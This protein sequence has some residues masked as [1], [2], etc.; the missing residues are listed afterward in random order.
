MIVRAGSGSSLAAAGAGC[1]GVCNSSTWLAAA[2]VAGHKARVA[3]MTQ[4]AMRKWENRQTAAAVARWVPLP[5]SLLPTRPLHTLS[6][7]SGLSKGPKQ[8]EAD[9]Q[10]SA[11]VV[12]WVVPLSR[13]R[14]LRIFTEVFISIV[15]K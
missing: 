12:V 13:Q 9:G 3:G 1:A 7:F 6:R 8:L 15:S 10:R 11:V 2:A 14:R 5:W 4:R